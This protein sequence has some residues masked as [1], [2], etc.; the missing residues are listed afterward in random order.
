MQ[1]DRDI[2]RYDD[3]LEGESYN[4]SAEVNEVYP[5]AEVRVTRAQY[6]T[7]HIKRL[8]EDRKELIIDPD[9][10]RGN[11]WA[12]KQ[13][14]ELVESIL[15]G[16]PIPVMYLFEM[17]DGKKQVVDGRQRISAILDFLN[18]KLVL[19]DLKI[20][21]EYNDC[22]FS[23]LD[24]KM[25][26]IFEDS[27]MYFYIIQPPTPE[28]VK[29]D[30]FDRVNRGGTRL[31]NQEMRNALYRGKSTRLISELSK[32]EEF[33]RATGHGISPKRKKDNYVVLRTISFYLLYRKADVVLKQNGEAIEYKSD[34]DDFL[35]KMMIFINEKASDELIADC[36][37]MFLRAMNNSYRIMGEDAYRFAAYEDESGKSR[38]RPINM[39]LFEMLAYIFSDDC[40]TN[41]SQI[42]RD[43]INKFKDT[44]DYQKM[45]MSN[46]DSSTNV[47]ERFST[48]KKLLEQ[49]KHDTANID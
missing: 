28:R 21:P 14:A 3:L 29:Y 34:I 42:T 11:V 39:P 17:R 4:S 47:T 23:D 36:R 12:K 8:V 26:G 19:K 48:A 9:F 37:T 22:K 2:D 7:L 46:V 30:I 16:I 1:E 25:Q 38:K 33:L 18:D 32:T 10:Q 40:V 15:M 35:A 43:A 31:T 44:Y 20:L 5:N 6:S 13:G 24:A 41:N 45:L 27:Q 49:I